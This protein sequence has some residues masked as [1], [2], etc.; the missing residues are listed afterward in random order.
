[1]PFYNQIC[2][3]S[4]SITRFGGFRKRKAEE[5]GFIHSTTFSSASAHMLFSVTMQS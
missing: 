2:L 3:F 5:I 1:M 4:Y